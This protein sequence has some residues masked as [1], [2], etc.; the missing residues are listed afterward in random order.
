MIIAS[1]FRQVIDMFRE[2]LAS[3]GTPSF[4]ITGAVS[5]EERVRQ[6]DEFQNNPNSPKL[7]FLQSK[8]GGTSLTLDMADDVVILDEMW[9]PDVQTQIEDRAHRL[10]RN[11]NVNIWYTR[12]LGTVEELIGT[13]V[14]ERNRVCRAVMDGSR[15]V[16]IKKKLLGKAA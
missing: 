13:T 6:Q 1:Q 16:E 14:E 3:K 8:A 5:A 10:S 7:F 11:H 12:S 15:G 9:D 4:A 2:D